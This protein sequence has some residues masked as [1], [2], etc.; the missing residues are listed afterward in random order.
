MTKSNT[1]VIT[2]FDEKIFKQS[3]VFIKTFCENY[4]EELDIDLYCLVPPE[5]MDKESTFIKYLGNTDKVSVKFIYSE[6][7]V[8]FVKDGIFSANDHITLNVW[9]RL[10]ISSLF[11][12]HN[13]AIYID[14]DTM[15]MRDVSPLINYKSNAKM[16]AKIEISDAAWPTFKTIDRLYFNAGVFITDLSYW[17][18]NN[19]EHSRAIMRKYKQK[20]DAWKKVKK[21]F[22]LILLI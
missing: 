15:V 11:P 1:V 17:R 13:K 2:S 10:F 5:L 16:I 9:Q 21:E 12:N 22:L 7:W 6:K 14:S 20:R 3:T 18:E 8:K 19:L 4:Q